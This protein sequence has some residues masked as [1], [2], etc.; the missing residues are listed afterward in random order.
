MTATFGDFSRPASQ[1]ITAA[2]SYARVVPDEVR[3]ALIRQ[4]DRIVTTLAHHLADAAP[5]GRPGTGPAEPLD[6]H[7][8]AMIE[9]R[10]ALRRAAHSLRH[11]AT[12]LEGLDG[13]D[14]HPVARHLTAAADNLAAG[15][16]VLQSHF[17][18]GPYGG[19]EGISY[20]APAITSRPVTSALMGELARHARTLAPWAAHLSVSGWMDAGAPASACLDLHAAT[21]WLW[22]AGSALEQHL[23]QH[24]PPSQGRRLLAAIPADFLPPRQ[25]P[26][27]DES[28]PDLCRSTAVTAE[29]L[30]HVALRF[31]SRARWS[32]L[33]TSTAW[34]KN[35]LA[36]AVT[37]HTSQIIL[38]SLSERATQLG[39]APAIQSGL[40][41]ASQEVQ[42]AWI[43]WRRIAHQWDTISTGRHRSPHV[44]PTVPEFS[45]LALQVARLAYRNPQWTPA[46]ADNGPVREAASLA[47]TAHDL[48][49]VLASVHHA[50]DAMT[51]AGTEDLSAVRTAIVDDRLYLPTRLMPDDCDIPRPY[52]LTP[53]S[54][55]NEVLTKYDTAIAASTHSAIT[56]DS[57]AIAL[58]A[59]TWTLAALRTSQ[60]ATCDPRGIRPMVQI[61]EAHPTAR[62]RS[63][64]SQRTRP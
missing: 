35:A 2:I 10:T 4:L 53:A 25:P 45:D 54:R 14:A 8:R 57:T 13:D 17:A 39:L 18:R 55:T 40:W 31:S 59:P 30:R 64:P 12:A 58:G 19:W 63:Q 24:P 62:F 61:T 22:V 7:T 20:W 21:R 11:A 3:P 49:Q 48:T 38:R 5:V 9:A 33:A 26:A 41:A 43:A 6:P 52:S 28:V 34:R 29:R 27:D 60:H 42:E 47:P 46:I 16:D 23:H 1:H 32:P 44:A 36:A 15:R 37:G 56:L 51:R 50:I